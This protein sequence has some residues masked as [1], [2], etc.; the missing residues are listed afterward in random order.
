M[1][2][3]DRPMVFCTFKNNENKINKNKNK[4]IK[5]KNKNKNNLLLHMT[6]L[7]SWVS[8]LLGHYLTVLHFLDF[9]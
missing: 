9:S 5:I 2:E 8:Q 6:V 4:L 3:S 1:K 7:M